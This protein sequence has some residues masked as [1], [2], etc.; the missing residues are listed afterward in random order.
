MIYL[1][2]FTF[3]LIFFVSRFLLKFVFISSHCLVIELY[4]DISSFFFLLLSSGLIDDP[5]M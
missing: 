3:F 4:F 1:I 5:R 2:I